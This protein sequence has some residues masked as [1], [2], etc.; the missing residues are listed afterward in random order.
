MLQLPNANPIPINRYWQPVD[1]S[2]TAHLKTTI[3]L[4]F[5]SRVHAVQNTAANRSASYLTFNLHKMV[6]MEPPPLNYSIRTRAPSLPCVLGQL[7]G[8]QVRS[9]RTWIQA[10]LEPGRRQHGRV[11]F[12]RQR[13]K[14]ALTGRGY[15]R[16]GTV[17]DG[18]NVGKPLLCQPRRASVV[19]PAALGLPFVNLGWDGPA[20]APALFLSQCYRFRIG[21]QLGGRASR[22]DHQFRFSRAIKKRETR[23]RFA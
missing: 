22:H 13:L 12:F 19:Y 4:K 10:P 20:Q 17:R 8:S 1:K 2:A 5:K 21:S 18:D 23:I 14:P 3:R 15:F 7:L 6:F 9:P 11:L 16:T